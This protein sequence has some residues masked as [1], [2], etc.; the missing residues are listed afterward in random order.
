[1][2][3]IPPGNWTFL[4]F[5]QGPI[6]EEIGEFLGRVIPISRGVDGIAK[7][8]PFPML[9]KIFKKKKEASEEEQKQDGKRVIN[10]HTA[11][12][13]TESWLRG[14]TGTLEEVTDFLHEFVPAP[15]LE[16]SGT[17]ADRIAQ[18]LRDHALSQT[19]KKYILKREVNKQGENKGFAT[20]WTRRK[21]GDHRKS[22]SYDDI[23]Y[24]APIGK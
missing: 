17:L 21:V 3:E 15:G 14:M 1:M 10:L 5:V 20:D 6:V 2:A 7:V 9:Q 19:K 11:I 23:D 13:I 12:S 16:S 22:I 18:D 4:A 8:L 24:P